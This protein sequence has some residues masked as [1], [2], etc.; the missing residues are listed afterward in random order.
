LGICG[1]LLAR[2]FREGVG[3]FQ[4]QGFSYECWFRCWRRWTR[5]GGVPV[6]VTFAESAPAG[7]KEEAK[8]KEES[9]ESD[10]DMGFGLFE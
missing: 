8:K 3:R 7:K 5:S 2:A 10:Y 1:T 6:T 4:C 9:E